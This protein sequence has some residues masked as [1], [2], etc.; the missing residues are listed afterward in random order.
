[1]WK[2]LEFKESC[3]HIDRPTQNCSVAPVPEIGDGSKSMNYHVLGGFFNHQWWFH[4][5]LMMAM[6]Y[7]AGQT[8]S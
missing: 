4:G 7:F 3:D 2:L 6:P 1:M 8:S 5:G